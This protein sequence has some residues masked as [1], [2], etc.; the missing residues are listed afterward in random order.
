MLFTGAAFM[1]ASLG[2]I[3]LDPSTFQPPRAILFLV[4]IIA[5]TG[6]SLIIIQDQTRWSDWLASVML[7]AF[8]AVGGWVA[9]FGPAERISGGLAFLPPETNVAL[10]RVIFGLGALL[11][12]GL[13]A[14][15]IRRSLKAKKK[16]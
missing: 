2:I 7:M 16:T 1:A 8:A 9:V 3:V 11:C 5:I 12:L 10:A 6:G 13:S 4:S 14:Y 15:A